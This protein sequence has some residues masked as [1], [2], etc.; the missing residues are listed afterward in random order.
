M[1]AHV[2]TDQSTDIS[3]I[4]AA[5]PVSVLLSEKTYSQFYEHI[6][7]ETASFVPD[8]STASGRKEIAAL[9]YKVT[10][11]K[12]AIDAAGKKLNEEARAQINAVDASRRKIRDEL[13]ALADEIRKPL[14]EWEDAEKRRAARAK[15]ILETVIALGN[16]APS[17]GSQEIRD[18]LVELGTVYVDP[19][20]MGDD[21][22]KAID[23]QAE[24][25]AH[26]NAH[27]DRALKAEAD[28]AELARLRA[29]QEE[30]ERLA[31]E[32]AEKAEAERLAR[33]RAEREAAEQKARE[34]RA[35]N[36]ARE[37]AEREAREAIER[38]EREKADA[39]AKA[40]AEARAILE[41]AER[42]KRQR[43]AEAKRVADEQAARDADKAHRSAV[44]KAAKEAVI[45]Q[46]TDEE[47]AKK[48][49][50][51]IIAGEVPHV[52]LRF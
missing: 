34:E 31:Q 41:A 27:L 44:M 4:V 43:E 14:T 30:R 19:E 42:E 36:A 6:K 47:T 29:E 18:R 25:L 12:T 3:A 33:E 5:N 52:T 17:D 51:A 11:T 38:A 2:Q 21:Y 26:L 9:A 22:D 1:N 46:G 50:L 15:E 45:A 13:D 35:A 23:A 39:I 10:R 20:I 7:S 24:S 28:A 49:V 32:A 48:I 37:Q 16:S 40:E 8:T